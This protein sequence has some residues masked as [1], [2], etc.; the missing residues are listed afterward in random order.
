MTI[1]EKGKYASKIMRTMDG[2][3]TV[4]NLY[5]YNGES[6][7]EPN[8]YS[9]RTYKTIKNAERAATKYLNSEFCQPQKI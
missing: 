8:V 1:I 7:E 3:F 9:L 5:N 6:H 2:E 4:I